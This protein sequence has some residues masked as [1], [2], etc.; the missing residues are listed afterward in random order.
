MSSLRRPPI[1][2][3]FVSL[4]ILFLFWLE[5][6]HNK[7]SIYWAGDQGHR[8]IGL[9][10]GAR[11]ARRRR[12]RWRQAMP[13]LSCGAMPSTEGSA[14]PSKHSR[15]RHPIPASP[16]SASSRSPRTTRVRAPLVSL[17]C[18][19]RR[20]TERSGLEPSSRRPAPSHQ[21]SGFGSVRGLG[22]GVTPRALVSIDDSRLRPSTFTVEVIRVNERRHSK[23]RPFD[24]RVDDRTVGSIVKSYVPNER[25]PQT[26]GFPLAAQPLRRG[27][28]LSP[29]CE[30]AVPNQ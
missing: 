25:V 19:H 7:T 5:F 26:L 30:R 17:G 9:E 6:C 3:S 2:F 29:W 13:S 16:P 1:E 24:D 27:D 21:P 11:R 23:R 10:E 22:F 28:S 8:S 18:G 20:A 15:C 12:I 4:F 14:Q